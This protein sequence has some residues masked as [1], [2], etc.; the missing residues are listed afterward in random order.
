MYL[1]EKYVKN[2]LKKD[3]SSNLIILRTNYKSNLTS[4]VVTFVNYKQITQY[5]CNKVLVLS[6]YQTTM[7]ELI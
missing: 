2:K 6:W 5:T 1:L 3:K 7:G 4:N